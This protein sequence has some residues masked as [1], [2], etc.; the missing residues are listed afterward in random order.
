MTV[1]ILF[2]GIV[3]EVSTHMPL[4]RHDLG[5]MLAVHRA[6]VSTHMPLARHDFGAYIYWYAKNGFYSHAS[7]EA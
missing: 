4:A 2:R 5:M 6:S 3:L 7:C 1:C